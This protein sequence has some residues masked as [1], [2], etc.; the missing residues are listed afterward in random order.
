MPI[1]WIC[2]A[3]LF[4]SVACVPPQAAGQEDNAVTAEEAA[5]IKA[6]EAKWREA[7]G[8]RS[9]MKEEGYDTS[10]VDGLIREGKQ[11]YDEGNLE[12]VEDVLDE[13]LQK[14]R[15]IERGEE[16]A[17]GKRLDL[18]ATVTAFDIPCFGWSVRAGDIDG[19]G[20]TDFVVGGLDNHVYA[21][22]PS[23]D[24]S[25]K[26]L[27]KR[28]VP[29]LP[30]QLAI[31]DVDGDGGM[32][33][34]CVALGPEGHVV[35][36]D[37]KGKVLWDRA[38]EDLLLSTAIGGGEVL[39]GGARL[40]QLDKNGKVLGD[41]DATQSVIGSLCVDDI[42]G[43]GRTEIILSNQDQGMF[44]LGRKGGLIWE[45]IGHRGGMKIA[46]YCGVM[47]RGPG[48]KTKDVFIVK[49]K[50]KI[51][52]FDG[53]GELQ[54]GYRCRAVDL[55][56][57]RA[58]S[59]RAIAADVA[60]AAGDELLCYGGLRFANPKHTLM[61]VLNGN[62]REVSRVRLPFAVL[63]AAS[64]DL[65]RG[66]KEELVFTA[67][68]EKRLY[69]VALSEEGEGNLSEPFEPAAVDA[70]LDR[71][72]AAVR[73][74]PD[75][76]DGPV[77]YH[78]IF[79]AKLSG[80]QDAKRF[81]RL[82]QFLRS[83]SSGALRL[84]MGIREVREE[85]V[86]VPQKKRRVT[87]WTTEDI[88][89]FVRMLKDEQ[90]YF[91]WGAASHGQQIFLKPETID[92]I[93]KAAGEYFL[94]CFSYETCFA[95]GVSKHRKRYL[96]FLEKAVAACTRNGK[97]YLISEP[98]DTW[99]FLPAN[100][101]F[102]DRIM[103]PNAGTVVPVYKGNEGRCPD[104]IA[105]SLAGL[106]RAGVIED[107]GV[108]TQDDMF[109]LGCYTDLIFQCPRDV[110]M[111]FDLACAAMGATYFRIEWDT[112]TDNYAAIDVERFD[113]AKR[114]PYRLNPHAGRHREMLFSLM[115]KGVVR[116]VEP[117]DVV[118]LSPVVVRLDPVPDLRDYNAKKPF[119]RSRHG[120]LAWWQYPLQKPWP[121][122]CSSLAYGLD[123]YGLGYFPRNPYGTVTVLPSFVTPPMGAKTIE[124]NALEVRLAGKA[125]SSADA[126]DRIRA[127]LAEGAERLPFR[128]EGAFLAAQR[129]GKGEYLLFLIDPEPLC[130]GDVSCRIV[131]DLFAGGAE[132]VDILTGES[133]EWKK[134]GADVAVPAGTF[135]LIKVTAIEEKR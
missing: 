18:K 121:D 27:W 23:A 57:E 106:R 21:F 85:G 3:V 82:G 127:L 35:L 100:K 43:D 129:T 114:G 134:G 40:Y 15:E 62:G 104:L 119:Y 83:Q 120:F 96:D 59:V 52:T 56:G 79:Q 54:W 38:T 25:G 117:R 66:G 113:L 88:L 4:L 53:N 60:G 74:L 80:P 98:F 8:L 19:D 36:L 123:H 75:R 67:Q 95:L 51:R 102:Y 105:G 11:A 73:K 77:R 1:K 125:S 2:C 124:T 17:A 33:I 99:L 6:L 90:I 70:N 87:T 39:A 112:E 103:K 14:L 58:I 118:S 71:I 7:R 48:K 68:Q 81:K 47:D 9:R 131:S 89:R 72:Y 28:E 122:Y 108:S 115:R 26:L 97:K 31:G 116:P 135:R 13:L 30:Y 69:A 132:L 92:R 46:S 109:R 41:S 65:A 86:D 84:E 16:A 29:G 24:G 22:R 93:A 50:G 76:S 107:W 42:N 34:A 5:Y 128:A 20:R 110:K 37:A 111:R 44:V 101:T 91:Y 133:I 94:G 32:E 63:D 126:A 55:V 45:E 49:T 78:G 61:Y 64:G 12:R 10:A 130:P